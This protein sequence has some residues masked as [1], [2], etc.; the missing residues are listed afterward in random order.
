[1]ELIK[2]AAQA[3]KNA[4]APYSK[5][6]VGAAVVGG[7]GKTYTGCNV[8]NSSFGATICAERV[9]IGQAIAAGETKI[10]QVAI[11][12]SSKEPCTPC[13]ICRQVISEF[14]PQA[15]IICAS[16]DGRKIEKYTIKELLPHSFDRTFLTK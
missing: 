1:M 16:E 6:T 9:A 5:F 11:I 7:S 4:Y 13:G 12:A 15:E 2:A 3:R 10:T 14:G 8:E